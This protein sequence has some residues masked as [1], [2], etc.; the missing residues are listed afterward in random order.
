MI[1]KLEKLE[2]LTKDFLK[3]TENQHFKNCDIIQYLKDNNFNKNDLLEYIYILLNALTCE[4]TDFK[5]ADI[6]DGFAFWLEDI[7]I[8][9]KSMFID[10]IES[11]A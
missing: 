3:D 11:E 5:I 1:N 4:N 10:Y 9:N 8:N 2:E 6:G 7:I